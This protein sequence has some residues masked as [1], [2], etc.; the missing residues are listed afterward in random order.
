MSSVGEILRRARQEQGLDLDTVA[1]RTKIS[2][3]FL[4]AIESDDRKRLPSGFFYKS[5]VEQYAKC[6]SLDTREIAAEID[7]VLSVDEPLPLPGFESVVARSVPPMTSAHRFHARRSYMSAVSLAL[8]L[9]GCSGVYV[10]WHSARSSL[11]LSGMIAGVRALAKPKANFPRPV[12]KIAPQPVSVQ[13]A[14]VQPAAVPVALASEAKPNEA[15]GRT[16]A[17]P[18]ANSDY[19]VMLDLMAHEATWLSVSSDGK[20]VF[21]GTLRPNETK[22]VGG[23]QFAKLRVGN[24]AGIEVRLNGKL[25]G[26]LG[27]RGQVLTVL[28]TPDNFQIFS[29]PKESD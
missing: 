17:D 6:L 18:T 14:A 5:F 11:S 4:E 27:A 12:A 8:V 25:L 22:T 19:K 15:D 21:S 2:A 29:A 24:A 28:F 3:K 10:W 16:G 9:V 20:P 7:R 13:R 23:K 1:A 26:P